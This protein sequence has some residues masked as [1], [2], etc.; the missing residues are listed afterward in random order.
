MLA[1]AGDVPDGLLGSFGPGDN[2]FSG[3][4]PVTRHPSSDTQSVSVGLT[5]TQCTSLSLDIP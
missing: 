4:R 2:I 1:A 3:H 5:P